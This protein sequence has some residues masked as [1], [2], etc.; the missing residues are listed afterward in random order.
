LLIGL[1]K[2]NDNTSKLLKDAGL[3]E[4]GLSAAIKELR[5]GKYHKQP[6][7]RAAI[8]CAANDM[9]KTSTNSP[10]MASWIRLLAAMKNS[11]YTAYSLP[12]LQ[13]NPILVGEPGVGK[14][15]IIEGLA[16]RI[17]NGDVPDN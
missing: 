9:V 13:N 12:P 6:D 2:I 14:T 8:Q 5:K 1:L 3:T 17:I 7:Q 16:N 15:A 10:A 11:P 4:K